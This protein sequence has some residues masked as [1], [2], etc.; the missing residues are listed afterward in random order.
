M[1]DS[2]VLDDM[3]FTAYLDKI[4]EECVEKFII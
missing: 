4:V 1:D 3:S 2:H